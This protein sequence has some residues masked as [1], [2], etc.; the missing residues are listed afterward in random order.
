[1]S[2]GASPEA[3]APLPAPVALLV[4]RLPALRVADV[5]P[6]APPGR[7]VA[8]AAARPAAVLVLL[9]PG[10]PGAAGAPGAGLDVVLIER[11]GGR[12]AHSGQ[13]A[14]PGGGVDPG[15]A[16]PAATALREAREEAALDDP[17]VVVLGALP[18]LVVPVSRYVVTPVLAWQPAPTPLAPGDPGEV[19]AVHR[20]PLAVLADPAHRVRVRVPERGEAGWVGPGFVVGE[21]LVWG[22]TALLLDALLR[23]AGLERPWA[24]ARTLDLPA[25][26]AGSAPAPG[27]GPGAPGAAP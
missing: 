3:G 21:L 24:P 13:V 1:V 8:P 23:L 9:S 5:A 12:G 16:S 11:A 6:G 26:F 17:A 10:A 18:A 2:L 19:A 14:L 25:R 27:P 22:F 7:L 15:D 4:Q 20:V